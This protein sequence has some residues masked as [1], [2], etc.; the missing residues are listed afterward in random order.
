MPDSLLSGLRAVVARGRMAGTI[1]AGGDGTQSVMRAVG[2]QAEDD[3]ALTSAQRRALTAAANRL[4]ANIHV[5]PGELGEPV[6]EHSRAAF[7]KSEIVKV[8]INSRDR[9]ECEL[10]GMELAEKIGGELVARLGHVV[11]LFRAREDVAD[12]G[13]S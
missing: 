9:D 8:R 11:V 12:S 1:F 5:A 7:G 13:G 2:D 4:P 3:V 6:I 10:V